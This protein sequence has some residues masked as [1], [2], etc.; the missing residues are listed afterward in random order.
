MTTAIPYESTGRTRQKARTRAA[1]IAAARELLAEGAAA[2][3][4]RAAGR[5]GISRTTAYRYFP[6]R[7]AL[8]LAVRPAMP[9]PPPTGDG[10]AGD[11]RERLDQTVEHLV[12]QAVALEP[13]LRAELRLALEPGTGAAG[14]ATRDGRAT[15]WL[16]DA[17]APLCEGMGAGEVRWLALAMRTTCGIEALVWLTDVAGLTRD[18]AGEIMRWSA[19]TLA[20]A[21]VGR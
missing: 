13:E 9:A 16:E 20:E 18:Q 17:L 5:A 19:R 2:T 12:T 21:A 11:A 14:P 3:V 10:T 15:G 4:E 1:L 6:S 8:L 7:R